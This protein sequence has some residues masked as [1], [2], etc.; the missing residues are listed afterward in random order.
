MCVC[1][2]GGGGGGLDTTARVDLQQ[3]ESCVDQDGFWMSY[4]GKLSLKPPRLDGSHTQLPS[5]G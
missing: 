3:R 4:R 5:H 1:V 2:G